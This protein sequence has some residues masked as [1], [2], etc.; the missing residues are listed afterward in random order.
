MN[1]RS[2]RIKGTFYSLKKIYYFLDG[3]LIYPLS[4]NKKFYEFR[5]N[6]RYCWCRSTKT[7][8]EG[9]LRRH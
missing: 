5:R 4:K 6:R 2:Y 9:P 8:R 3:F 7:S 1:R